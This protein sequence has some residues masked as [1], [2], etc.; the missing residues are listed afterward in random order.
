LG[1]RLYDHDTGFD[2][3]PDAGI[4]WPTSRLITAT[5]NYIMKIIADVSA[6]NPSAILNSNKQL[7]L[8]APL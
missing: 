3:M 5:K 4:A 1:T 8:G 2:R 7:S 6:V